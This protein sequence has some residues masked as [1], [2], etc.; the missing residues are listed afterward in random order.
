MLA[1][2]SLAAVARE[3]N[4]EG[5]LTS[6]GSRWTYARLRDVL[7]RPRNAGLLS[8]A[9]PT[10]A[11]RDRGD[12]L[13]GHAI[14]DEETW[15][16]VHALLTDSSRRLQEGNAPRWLGSGIYACGLWRRGAAAGRAVRRHPGAQP[17][18]PLPVPVHRSRRT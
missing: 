5:R 6:T 8:R 10:G 3:F 7:I 16:A 9:G 18:P 4:E 2:R 12:R 14:V 15:A 13:S 11:V 17:H 1:G